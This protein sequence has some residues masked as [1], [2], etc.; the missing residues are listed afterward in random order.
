MG[1]KSIVLKWHLQRLINTTDDINVGVCGVKLRSDPRF[2]GITNEIMLVTCGTCHI[3]HRL[4]AG[5]DVTL[6]PEGRYP[7]RNNSGTV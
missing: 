3:L 1:R 5:Q 2:I 4:A 7:W 6:H